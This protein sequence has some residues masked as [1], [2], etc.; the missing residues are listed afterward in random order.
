MEWPQHTKNEPV[1]RSKDI[2]LLFLGQTNVLKSTNRHT[3]M[4]I[5]ICSFQNTF[6]RSAHLMLN[7]W[8]QNFCLLKTACASHVGLVT[9]LNS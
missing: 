4:K 8:E 3:E 2:S 7:G 1:S 5:N 6:C 9:E